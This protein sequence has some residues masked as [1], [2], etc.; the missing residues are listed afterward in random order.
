[1]RVDRQADILGVA[2]HLDRQRHLGD[3]IAG[4]RADDA[5]AEDTI[6]R[7]VEQQLRHAFVPIQRQ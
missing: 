1:M 3:Q 7:R 5:G 4:I 2:A 6:G